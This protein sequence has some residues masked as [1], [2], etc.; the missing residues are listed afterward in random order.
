MALHDMIMPQLGESV[1]EGTI[2]KWLKSA[3]DAVEAD[4]MILE[5]STDKVDSEIPAPVTG[6]LKELLFNEGDVVPV[7][8]VIARIE[9]DAAAGGDQP[10][11]APEPVADGTPTPATEAP[12]AAA[13][14]ATAAPVAARGKRFYSPLVRRIAKENNID[15]G[16]LETIPGSGSNGRLTRKDLEA[17]LAGGGTGAPSGSSAPAA[18]SAAPAGYTPHT[19]GVQAG[20]DV[21][22][23]PMDNMRKI[24]AESMV[25]SKRIS[26]HVLS[27]HEAD[28]THLAAWRAK[29]KEGFRQ[30]YGMNL[31]YTPMIFMAVVKA[32]REFPWV[33]A[34]VDGTNVVVRKRINLGFAVALDNSG[35]IVPVI[36]DADE[37]NFLGMARSVADLADRARTKKLKPDDISGGT[38][39]VT[40]PG[41]FGTLVG[42]PIIA[43]P[44]VAILGM[45]AIQKRPVVTKDDAIAIRQMMYV[46]LAY[47][48]RVV[49][50]MMAGQ[51]LG[52]VVEEIHNF[53]VSS[54]P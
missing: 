35:L 32:L 27:I 42:F 49:D 4:E 26:P 20:D 52:R 30:K 24:I 46:S 22:I 41:V 15:F 14:P 18:S 53:D 6:V 19:I 16:T 38:F 10:A 1:A 44:N 3:G 11:A 29:H 40:N 17:W 36:K 47:D 54:E 50:G 34:S 7:R 13:A 21:E 23:I 5:I 28:V 2:L 33:N 39:S 12:A 43:Q 8:T 31:T 37:K 48:H 51:F 45:G 25:M 9:T